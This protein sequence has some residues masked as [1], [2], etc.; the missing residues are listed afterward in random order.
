MNC[1]HC[2]G[3]TKRFGK[4]RKGNQ[5]FR[6]LSCGKTAIAPYHKPL[7]DMRV[8]LE[9]ALM[10]LQLLIEGCSIRSAERITGVG[11]TAILSLLVKVG[12][13]CERL[14][15]KHIRNVK[16]DHIQ[17]DEI[18]AFVQMKEKTRKRRGK[19]EEGLG[20]SYTWICMEESSKL[21]IAW[22][23]GKRTG[24][25]AEIF[26]EKIYKAVEGTSNRF[27]MSTDGYG[28]YPDAVGYS[29]GTRV[30]YA[31]IIKQYAAPEADDHR[32]SPSVCIGTKTV[33]VIGQPDMDKVCT[34]HI[35]RQNLTIRMAM[36]RFTRLTNGFSKKWANLH[37][38]LSL[39]C[40]YYNVCRI[41]KTIRCTPAMEAGITKRVWE[42]KDL[43]AA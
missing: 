26:L 8:P 37:A 11:K 27:Q 41:H 16:V 24:K 5:R 22:H 28:A 18:W 39:Q 42:L 30:D 17:A 38:A 2:D 13:K 1:Q 10:V 31:Q 12:E 6:C 34:S 3:Q 29:L 7:D 35:E 32:Y 14:F 36:R 40:A 25:D 23:L 43:L 4:D 33:P 19:D 20:D 21:I 15:E 9:K